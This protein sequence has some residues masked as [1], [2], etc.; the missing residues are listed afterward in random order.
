MNTQRGV[1]LVEAI[2]YFP[3]VLCTVIAMLYLGLFNMQESALG[4]I[5]QQAVMEAAREEAYPGYYVFNMNNGK[6]LDFEWGG[7]APSKSEVENYYKTQHETIGDLYR[8]A[9][10]LMERIAELLGG[11]GRTH[12]DYTA[13]YAAATAGITMISAG[14]IEAPEITMENGFFS[15]TVRVSIKHKFQVPGVIR[16]LGITQESYTL[17]TVA[18]KRVVNPGEFVRNVDL[19]DDMIH[20]VLKAFGVEDQVNDMLAKI[21]KVLTAILDPEF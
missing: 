15:S 20:E 18:I 12:F 2:I 1:A 14:T 5:A 4:Y 11:G 7:D 21:N 6:N 9:G 10:Y 3:M 17:E 16:Y 8:E 13:K 19:A